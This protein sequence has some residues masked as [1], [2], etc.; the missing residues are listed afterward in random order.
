MNLIDLQ[1]TAAIFASILWN[2]TVIFLQK[3]WRIY[4]VF[5]GKKHA[6]LVHGLVVALTTLQ[7]VAVALFIPKSTWSY[8]PVIILG[9]SICVFAAWLFAATVKD[10]GKGSLVSSNLF[11]KHSKIKKEFNSAQKYPIYISCVLLFVGLS[12]TFGKY[13]YLLAAACLALGLIVVAKTEKS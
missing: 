3:K 1:I 8:R 13:G 6:Q 4:D 10:I 11:T 2:V 9:V 12:I 7:V 5:I